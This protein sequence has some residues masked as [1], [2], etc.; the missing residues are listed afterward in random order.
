MPRLNSGQL[1]E[2]LQRKQVNVVRAMLARACIC[3]MR[4]KVEPMKE[5]AA[6]VRRHPEGSVAWAQTRQ[7]DGFLEA[8][9]GLFQAA[10]R[11]ARGFTRLSTIKTVIFLIVGKLDFHAIN[12]HAR[13]P[14]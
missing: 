14:T 11:R 13:Q 12:H 10:K 4:S 9:S 8:I 3:V 5:V 2:I 1:R 6:L 7:T